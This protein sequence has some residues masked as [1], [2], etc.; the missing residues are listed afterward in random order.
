LQTDFS[1]RYTSILKPLGLSDYEIRVFITLIGIGPTNYRVL[2]TESNVPTGKIYQ[3][4]SSLESKGFIEVVNGKPKLFKAAEPK[5]AFRKRLRQIE[6]DYL[7]L[8]RSIKEGLQNLQSE[9]TQKYGNTQGTITEVIVGSNAFESVIKNTLLKAE[10]E[11]LVSSIDLVSRLHLEEIIKD[12]QLKGVSINALSTR[13]PPSNNN[14]SKGLSDELLDLWVNTRV[15]K[16]IPSKYLIVDNRSVS[17][18]LNGYEEE[19]CV[20]IQSAPLCQVLR[21]NFLQT[22]SNGTTFTQN[23]KNPKLNVSG[24]NK[25]NQNSVN[26]PIYPDNQNLVA[27]N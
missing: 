27:N 7:D 26:P 4:L 2:V 13:L 5:K 9:Y 3:V 19:T 23:L 21:E 22:W 11:V 18:F 8:E 10:D 6:D 1:S 25:L 14:I 24:V 12:L 16:S 20:Q 17:L 15:S